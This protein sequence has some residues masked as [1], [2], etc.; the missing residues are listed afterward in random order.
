LVSSNL[1]YMPATFSKI[2]LKVLKITGITLVSLVVLMFLLPYLFPGLIETK[3]RQ[4]AKGS[5]RTELNFSG[6]RLSF[7]KHFPSL[8]LTLYDFNLKGSDPFP[9]E[10]LVEAHEIALGVDL[11]SVF[12]RQIRIDKIFLTNAF[13]NIQVDKAGQA[14][15]DVYNA[16]KS[17]PSA[18]NAAD[19]GSASLKIKKILIEGSKLV[20]NDRSLPM[21]INARGLYY[22]GSGDLDKAIFDLNTH[23]E[24]ESLD[25]YYDRQAY[26]LS[27][28]VN[29]DLVTKIN[30][31]S[32]AFLFEKN[33]LTINKL[34]VT[35][36]GRFGFLKNGYDM[37]FKL[38]STDSDLHDI[39]TALP[40]EMVDWLSK[41]EVKGVGDIDASL[42]GKYIASTN[43]M[44]DL[45]LNMKI[46][47]GF[48]S[49]AQAPSPVKN[50]F[51]NFQTR[52]PGLNTDS[53]SAVVDSLYFNLDKDYFNAVVRLKGLKQPEVV[54]KIN[55]EI[56]LEKWGRAFG[57]TPFTIKG[58]A[59]FHLQADGK[60]TTRIVRREGLRSTVVD[61]VITSIPRFK[62]QSTMRDGY[63]KYASLPEAVNSISFD[64]L[65]DCPDN[66]YKH[67]SLELEN[68]NARVLTS[69]IKGFF[70]MGNA[71]DFPIDAN[72]E[73][74]FHL[75]DLKKVY[76]LDSIS[77][78]GDLKVNIRTKGNYQPA[79]KKFPV[80]VAS[81]DLDNG[82]I[83]TKYY[84][85]PLEQI[86]VSAQ[87]VSNKGSM[88]D[89]AVTILPVSFL[90]EG[91][92][93]TVSADLR[94]FDNLRYAIK[95]KGILDLGKIYRVF[96]LKGVDVNGFIETNLSLKGRQSDAVAGRYDLLF[97]SGTMKVRDL[98]V[99]SE[100]FPLPFLIR[101][102]LFRFDQDKMWFDTFN[103]SYGKS[104][105]TL[106]GH[107][108]N[109][110]D[111]MTNKRAPLK[112][113][114]DLKSD[115]I[116]VDEFTA[117]AQ[118]AAGSKTDPAGTPPA[119][120][121]GN[122]PASG[123]VII[124]GDLSV[125]FNATAEKVRYNG[126][127]LDSFRGQLVLDSGRLRLN[128]TGFSLIGAPVEMDAAYQSL[129]PQRAQFNYHIR[130]KE[131]DV[132]RAYKEI[133]LFHDLASSAS[134][135]EGIISLDYQLAGKLDGSMHPVYP[136]LKGGGVL[137][138][139]KVKMKGLKLFGAVSKE[140]GK[141]V[142]DPDLSKVDIKSTINNNLITIERTRMKVSVF[143]LRM[144]GQASFDGKL[145]L[146]FRVGLPPF[147]VI[148]I[149]LKISGTQD[150]PKVRGG[151]GSKK[152]DLEQ[153]E[154]KEEEGQDN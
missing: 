48:I 42:A 150:N 74:I 78:A 44:P 93:F 10:T 40:P 46:R 119:G 71:S 41:T 100:L 135:A 81:L 127:D 75:G 53:L 56:D 143:K 31:N 45:S 70:K 112:G 139:K 15:Y 153:T 52:L 33:Q 77:L 80:T 89:L 1:L 144:E 17:E 103:A 36:T 58:R 76:P 137:S 69:Y 34:P 151:R 92:P 57:M 67:T 147:G 113:S 115:F 129:S 3:I 123:V 50:L 118:P 72:L 133:K 62:L 21:L 121:A 39:F 54:A 19:T 84:P 148:G 65:A 51:L 94:D 4:W 124:P 122:T 82:N 146:R 16:K 61:T 101:T 149:P 60:Y 97:N 95:S 152:D 14:N 111:Y 29:A 109:V 99:R 90:L 24:I 23:T 126:I 30:T 2:F 12:S 22:R 110:L 18:A 66:D 102:G 138:V 140:S 131:F 59:V 43:E 13:I 38:R 64:L 28:K 68:I 145:N 128:K 32:L 120:A 91:Q 87:V 7:F 106:N 11:S 114:F 141:D 83:Q 96:A 35:F 6:A 8:T 88:N 154:D 5:I 117:F 134:K 108:S 85:H 27:K 20:Y 130:A 55:S 86:K 125:S 26:F 49:N 73:T 47:D 79:Q 25:F 116:L 136:S 63:F 98:Q 105:L 104:H 9:K 142:N 132:K 107:L 37:D